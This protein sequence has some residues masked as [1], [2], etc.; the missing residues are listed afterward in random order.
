[1][2]SKDRFITLSV[3]SRV[4]DLNFIINKGY[5]RD[6][7]E[8]ARG[9]RFDYWR[10]VVS[11]EYVHLDCDGVTRDNIRGFKGA[12]RGGV[13]V[14]EVRFSE[15]ISHP[16]I[17]IRTKRQI[18]KANEDDFLISFQLERECVVSQNGR[19]ALLTPGSFALYDSTEEY[20]LAFQKP[21]HQIVL[22][23][24]RE[25]LSRHLLEPERY[26]AI[27]I[28]GREGIGLVLQN[29]IFSLAA[30]LSEKRSQPGELLTENLVNLIALSFSSS[31]LT[32]E[33]VSSDCVREALVRRIRQFIDNNLFDRRLNNSRIAESQGISVRYLHKLFQAEDESIHEM[34]LRRRLE[35]AHQILSDANNVGVSIESVAL[36]VGFTGSPHFSRAF[37]SHFGV[38]PSQVSA[39]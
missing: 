2:P 35:A 38:C 23:M 37:K 1:M 6:V 4:H 14:G 18:A 28:S 20:S 32:S 39:G 8:Q 31:V 24:P 15:V 17:A 19:R 11:E 33:V 34:I 27:A 16:Q 7:G 12:L 26:T 36:H 22:Q 10:D 29:F 5:L 25:V 30:E 13:C 9:D 3:V 21:F